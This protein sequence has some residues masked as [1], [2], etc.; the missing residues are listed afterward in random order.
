[1]PADEPPPLPGQRQAE[2]DRQAGRRARRGAEGHRHGATT[3]STC[4]CPA[5]CTR[6]AWSS[7]RRARR[8]ISIDTSEAERYPG[9]RA[10]HVLEPAVAPAQLRDPDDEGRGGSLSRP[11]AISASRSRQ[12]P[13]TSQRAADAAAQLVKVDYER[14][15]ARHHARRSDAR[16]RA[17]GLPGADRAA[18]HGRRRR[19]P[20]GPAAARQRARARHRPDVRPAARRR[21]AGARRG[22]RRRRGG[23]PHAGADARAD[24]DAR[25]RRRLARGRADDLRVDAVHDQRARRG[26]RDVRTCRR[27]RCASSAISPAA[28]SARSTA[29]ATS[30]CWRSTCRARPARRCA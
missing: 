11:F 25:P 26:G 27:A 24:G 4:S 18:R 29:S 5:C 14:A 3:P 6:G 1:M 12:S 19:R 30:G 13:P 23:I 2:G 22:R 20:A 17:R 7:T 28:G 9:V 21:R 15:A 16:R 10:V 8:V